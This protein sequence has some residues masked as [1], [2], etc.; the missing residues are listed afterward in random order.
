MLRQVAVSRRGFVTGLG[1]VVAGGLFLEG[2][3]W[4]PRRVSVTRHTIGS[5]IESEHP[6]RVVQL[7]DLHL[8]AVG[9]FERRIATTVRELEPDV[10]LLT[11]DSVDRETSLPLLAE[12]LE[13]L[14]QGVARYATL[15]NW[16][17]WSGV[18]LVELAEVYGRASCRLLVNETA[19]HYHDGIAANF[20]G[21]DDFLAG[22]PRLSAAADGVTGGANVVVLSH[23]PGYVDEPEVAGAHGVAAVLSGHT[24]G[25]QVAVG[26]WVPVRPPGSGPYV[27]GWYRGEGPD[28]Y[29]SRGLGTSVVPIRLGCVPEVA[30]FEWFLK[31]S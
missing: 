10:V 11:G 30:L 12:F 1:G 4:E 2:Y 17:Y 5:P 20:V 9:G 23:C 26:G 6:L 7:T 18:D 3:V 24:H 21:L 19:T 16:E 28:L 22:S 31:S 29:V 14:P 25:G 13:L 8:K 15:G 27:A